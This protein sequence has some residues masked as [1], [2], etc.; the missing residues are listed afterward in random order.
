MTNQQPSKRLLEQLH[1]ICEHYCTLER[2]APSKAYGD[3]GD[4]LDIGRL[5]SRLMRGAG[6]VAHG[7]PAMFSRYGIWANTLKDLVLR[8]L[9]DVERDAPD[10]ET[11]QRLQLVANSLSAFCD[12]QTLF[13]DMG[14]GKVPSYLR[15][16]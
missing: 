13:D 1:T 16:P 6:N 3:G 14:H 9:R 7:D 12:I 5:R 2:V 4:S 8:A 10:G 15:S 11:V